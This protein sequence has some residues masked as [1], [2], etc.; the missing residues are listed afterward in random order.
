MHL[1]TMRG[2]ST[3][4]FFLDVTSAF[5]AVVRDFVVS[6]RDFGPCGACQKH[7]VH[8]EDTRNFMETLL[9]G[10]MFHNTFR[11]RG[12]LQMHTGTLGSPHPGLTPV[13]TQTME[14]YQETHSGTFFMLS[15]LP[16]SSTT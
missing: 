14:A 13:L 9:I 11:F 1:T 16:R 3:C 2:C 12:W 10:P 4:C 5:D 7:G 8:E 6:F 15:Y